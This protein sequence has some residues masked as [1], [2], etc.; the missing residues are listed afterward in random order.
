MPDPLLNLLLSARRGNQD[1]AVRFWNDCAPGLHAL[2]LSVLSDHDAADD[3]LQRVVCRTIEMPRRRLRAIKDI[4]AW[5]ARAV[6]NDALNQR[7]ERARRTSRERNYRPPELAAPLDSD[8]PLAQ[9]LACIT[10][11]QREVVLLKHAAGLTFDQIALALDLNRHTAA[12]RYRAA[13]ASLRR[14]L[15]D[16]NPTARD[17]PQDE[18]S[19]ARHC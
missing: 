3:T 1:A 11:D 2:A 7:R 6:R 5:L 13:I 10:Q 18:V 17:R 19:H 8:E 16:D 12:G 15:A 14:E 4:R 9:A